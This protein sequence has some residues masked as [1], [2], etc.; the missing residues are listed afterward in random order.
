MTYTANAMPSQRATSTSAESRDTSSSQPP[1]VAQA[2]PIAL[3]CDEVVCLDFADDQSVV[4]TRFVTTTIALARAC[5]GEDL[6]RVVEDGVAALEQ[7]L[8]AA[9]ADRPHQVFLGRGW[10]AGLAAAAALVLRETAQMT[11][12]AYPAMEYRHGPIALAQ[13]RTAVWFL[14]AA[15]AGLEDQVASTGAAIV[16][17]GLDPLAQLVQ[18]QRV[19]VALARARGL[20]PDRP[21][22][23]S[24]SIV[25]EATHTD[26][27]P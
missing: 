7:P 5:M 4:Q 1:T 9:A 20:D 3:A 21:P 16:R 12:E 11:C 22:H 24:R 19:A 26:G 8:P 18:V 6:G 23:L 2:S 25:L 14:G 17:S 15:P 27:V 13:A 10:C